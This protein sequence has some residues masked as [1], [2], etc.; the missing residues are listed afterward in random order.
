MKVGFKTRQTSDVEWPELRAIWEMGD[1]LEVFDSAWLFDHFVDPAGGGSHEA[2]TLIGALAAA[3]SRL[4][5]GHLVLS[6]SHRHPAL[7]AKMAVT[8]DHISH[9]RLVMGLGAGWNEAEHSM[10]GWDF[11]DIRERLSRLEGALRVLKGMWANPHG[12]SISEGGYRLTDALCLP[13]PITPGGP[14]IWLGTQG[15]RGLRLAADLADGWNHTGTLDEFRE[16][17]DRLLRCCDEVGRNPATLTISAQL[18]GG[19]WPAGALMREILA[20]A[21]GYAEAGADLVVLPV[22][23]KAGPSGLQRL[24][25]EVAAPLAERF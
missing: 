12:C 14:P 4:R 7:V 17:R 8:V 3:T 1:D 13:P 25:E 10:Y 19:V 22:N 21:T 11:P 6:N 20:E 16:K 18:F 24:A 5:I 15:P 23:M 2:W 9:G